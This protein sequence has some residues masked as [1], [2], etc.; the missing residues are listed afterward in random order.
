VEPGQAKLHEVLVEEMARRS[1]LAAEAGPEPEP[2]ASD[3]REL[4]EPVRR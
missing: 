1:A 2:P 3:Q 4:R